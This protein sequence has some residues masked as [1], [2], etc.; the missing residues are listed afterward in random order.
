M[1]LCKVEGQERSFEWP[2][3]ELVSPFFSPWGGPWRTG[4]MHGEQLS[5][6]LLTCAKTRDNDGMSRVCMGM[7]G[8]AQ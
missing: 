3:L 4:Q 2:Y 5:S 6:V 7:V 1:V 8:F